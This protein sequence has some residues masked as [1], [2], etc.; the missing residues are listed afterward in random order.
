M[1]TTLDNVKFPDGSRHSSTALGLL[2]A[3]HIMPALLLNTCMNTNM[4]LTANSFRR[5]FPDKIFL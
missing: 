5:V 2:S 1:V 3:T 4:Q